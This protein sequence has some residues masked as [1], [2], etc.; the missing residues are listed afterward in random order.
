MKDSTACISLFLTG[1]VGGCKFKRWLD[2]FGKSKSVFDFPK[3]TIIGRYFLFD[4]TIPLFLLIL[5]YDNLLEHS[6]LLQ[7]ALHYRKT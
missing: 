1:N 4:S 2:F 5:Q 3:R 6:P 7:Q